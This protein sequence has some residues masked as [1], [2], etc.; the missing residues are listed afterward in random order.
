MDDEEFLSAELSNF[1]RH[2]EAFKI[3]S[4]HKIS[5]KIREEIEPNSN[6]LGIPKSSIIK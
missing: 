2:S 5:L 1:T 6:G 3:K 4:P